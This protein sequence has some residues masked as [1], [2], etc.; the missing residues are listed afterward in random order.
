MTVVAAQMQSRTSAQARS[1]LLVSCELA[2]LL[3]GFR[4]TGAR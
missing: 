3:F 1:E 4:L 2:G